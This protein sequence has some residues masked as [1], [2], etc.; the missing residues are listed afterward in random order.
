MREGGRE[1][2]REIWSKTVQKLPPDLKFSLNA[3]QDTLPHNA[4]WRRKENLVD[5]VERSKH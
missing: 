1:G 4:K 2:E 3:V 5:C